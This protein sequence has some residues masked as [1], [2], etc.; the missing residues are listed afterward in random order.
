MKYMKKMMILLLCV[1]MLFTACSGSSDTPPETRKGET[2]PARTSEAETKSGEKEQQKDGVIET[3]S[4]TEDM[5]SVDEASGVEYVNSIVVICFDENTSEEERQQI[6]QGIGGTTAGRI[7]ALDQLQVKVTATDLAGLQALCAE[8]EKDPRVELASYDSVNSVED[9]PQYPN[10]PKYFSWEKGGRINRNWGLIAVEAPRIWAYQ[11]LLEPVAVGVVDIG[12]CYRHPDV[13]GKMKKLSGSSDEDRSHGTH[14]SGILAANQNNGTGVAGV[15][16]NAFL[17]T[18][19]INNLNILD[20]FSDTDFYAGFTAAVQSDAKVINASVGGLLKT[21]QVDAAGKKASL[22]LAKLLKRG[23]DFVV[24]QSAGNDSVDAVRN[25]FFSSVTRAN[26][27]TQLVS[28]D[29]I[30]DRI[31]IV[32]SARRSGSGYMMSR[33]SNGGDRVDLCAPGTNIYNCM[34][35]A[36]VTDDTDGYNTA[37]DDLF[38]PSQLDNEEADGE[39]YCFM[40]GTSMAAPYVSGIAAMTWGACPALIGPQVKRLLCDSAN[41]SIIVRDNPLSRN[42]VGEFPLVSAYLPVIRALNLAGKV[43]QKGNRR[44]QAPVP[45]S[46]DTQPETTAET[47]PPETTP[48]ETTPQEPVTSEEIKHTP[49]RA[50]FHEF[51][52]AVTKGGDFY[53]IAPDWLYI[54]NAYFYTTYLARFG[55]GDVNFDGKEELVIYWNQMSQE[56]SCYVYD[57]DLEFPLGCSYVD[58]WSRSFPTLSTDVELTYYSGGA[59]EMYDHETG[60]HHFCVVDYNFWSRHP[61]LNIPDYAA[62]YTYLSVPDQPVN[63]TYHCLINDSADRA[64]RDVSEADMKAL[65]ADLRAGEARRVE[66]YPVTQENL[67]RVLQ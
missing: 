2:L 22:I 46:A 58:G 24:V 5:I 1:C 4:L 26:C 27:D 17:L 49:E 7:D 19:G 55:V 3:Y 65:L 54:D 31:I 25:N 16:P 53:P 51:M 6:V 42:A 32:G 44:G 62:Y 48:P 20:R 59:V 57:A 28:A 18:Y 37:D 8:L 23:H 50:A 15:S 30:L 41:S 36:D 39:W 61:E 21:Q 35:D 66:L 34:T 67:D 45:T 11:D 29:E 40:S 43:D 13:G 33:F 38:D 63:G 14:V 10:D 12:F 9:E 47:L 60:Y 56:G 52:G 64:G